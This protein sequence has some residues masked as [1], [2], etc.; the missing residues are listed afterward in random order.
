MS[1]KFK[2][3]FEYY[4]ESKTK[5]AAGVASNLRLAME[6]VPIFAKYAKGSR[7]VDVDDN[8]Y[9]DYIMAYGPQIL[10][11]AHDRFVEAVSNQAS[12][13]QAYG[14][15]HRGE[16]DLADKLIKHIPC[17]ELVSLNST[18]SEAVHTAVRLARAFTKRNKIIRFEGQY[19][20]WLDTIFTS[21]NSD[22]KVKPGTMG[23]DPNALNTVIQ[24]PW[25]DEEIL[26]ET[27]AKYGDE[28]A[29]VLTEPY[30]CNSGCL[31][32]KKGY[33][34]KVREITQ[35][36]GALLIFDEV[37]TGFRLGLG[38]AQ[39]RLGI[40][41]DLATFGKALAGG[42]PLSAI[43]GK[44]EIMDYISRSDVF[45]MGTLNGNPLCTAGA[46][47]TI[48]I[49]EENNGKVYE[50]MTSISKKL[51]D[52]MKQIADQYNVP[53]VI[54]SQGTVFHTMI[55]E[56]EEN[57]DTFEQFEKRDAEKFA[58]LAEYL[59]EEGVMVRPSGLWY[60]STSHTEEDIEITL[61][62]FEKAI[63]RLS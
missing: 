21:N 47:A 59:L 5:L 63:K 12:I 49:L 50:I 44:K 53:F 56:S 32:P 23:Q 1:N 19:H 29:C 16:I 28:I 34:E 27:F 7:V 25:N 57:I 60:I 45:H 26:E 43:A 11:H 9:V 61:H 48:E 39:E 42:M 18:G 3:S 17:A 38:G 35:Q 22:E 51:T 33:M 37:I 15:Q 54:N 30:M 4:Q 40:T 41:P 14:V 46:I 6:P 24:I 52:G 13:G 8:E 31:P 58:K 62:A 2:N 36:Y 10:G 55:I 20:G